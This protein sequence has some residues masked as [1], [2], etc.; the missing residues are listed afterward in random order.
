MPM[1]DWFDLSVGDD[2]AGH[3]DLAIFGIAYDRSVFFRRGAAGGPARM[4]ELSSKIPPC[5]ESGASL[6]ARTVLDLGDI[7]PGSQD[8]ELIPYH[9]EI[10]DRWRSARSRGLPLVLGG[11]H[12]ISIPL[13]TAAAR[14]SS[15]PFGVIWIDAHPDLCDEYDGSRFSHASV[16]RRALDAPN[17]HPEAVT[18]LGVR[19][20]E[21]EE[22]DYL[23][24]NPINVM[25]AAALASQHALDVGRGLVERYRDIPVY[26]SIDID[27]FDPAYAPGTGIPDAGGLSTRWVLDLLHQFSS[28]DVLGIDL[29]EVAP[30]LDVPSDATSLLALKLILE[31]LH[32]FSGNSHT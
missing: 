7:V 26:L 27:A 12:S 6:N 4:R 23:A 32:T 13:F 17:L 5:T 14:T 29:V 24:A 15:G 28:L 2:C 20:Y 19:S 1:N 16:L 11:D 3:V 8:D 22:L 25:T 10:R 30:P 31:M 21:V 9:N 18:M